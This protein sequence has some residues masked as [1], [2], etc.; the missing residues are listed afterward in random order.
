MGG[1]GDFPHYIFIIAHVSDKIRFG[2]TNIVIEKNVSP[3]QQDVYLAAFIAKQP[4][5]F[6][7]KN[8]NQPLDSYARI[9]MTKAKSFICTSYSCMNLSQVCV[10]LKCI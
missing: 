10:C 5:S 7:G 1:E 2:K 4:H 6:D 3:N 8:L 9:R